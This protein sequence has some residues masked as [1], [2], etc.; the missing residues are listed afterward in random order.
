MSVL[1][2]DIECPRRNVEIDADRKKL[3]EMKILFEAHCQLKKQSG[4]RNAKQINGRIFFLNITGHSA[5]IFP[6]PHRIPSLPIIR[7]FYLWK[8]K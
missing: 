2:N 5:Y 3:V 6:D 4:E 1:R 8:L 7:A